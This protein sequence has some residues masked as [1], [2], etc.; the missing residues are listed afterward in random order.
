[1][2]QIYKA[3]QNAGEF[4]VT[5]PRSYHSGFNQGLNFAEAVNFAS[6]DWLPIGRLSIAHYASLHRYPVFSHDELICKMADEYAHLEMRLAVAT[7]DDIHQ[8]FDRE[9]QLRSDILVLG[10]EKTSR[11]VLENL[12]DDERQC[13]YCKTTCFLSAVRCECNDCKW[14]LRRLFCLF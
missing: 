3:V 11:N 7:Y 8:M 14:T 13:D 9:K 12:K 1:M 4:I 2:F 6:A 5:F 10:V